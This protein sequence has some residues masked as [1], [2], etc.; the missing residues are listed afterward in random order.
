MSVPLSRERTHLGRRSPRRIDRG[1]LALPAWRAYSSYS[2][3]L[4]FNEKQQ[5]RVEMLGLHGSLSLNA[6][7]LLLWL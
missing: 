1:P 2:C 7:V 6:V 4:V 3:F 5:R